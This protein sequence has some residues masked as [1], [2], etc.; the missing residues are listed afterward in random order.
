LLVTARRLGNWVVYMPW[1]QSGRMQYEESEKRD[2]IVRP[3]QATFDLT[4]RVPTLPEVAGQR[5]SG[6]GPGAQVAAEALIVQVE[7]N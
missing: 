7:L 4:G 3:V 2:H 1:L 5:R 6:C